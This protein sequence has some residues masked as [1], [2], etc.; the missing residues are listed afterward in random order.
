MFKIYRGVSAKVTG[1]VDE[2]SY[3]ELNILPRD[4]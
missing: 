2:M 1:G 4:F 3:E